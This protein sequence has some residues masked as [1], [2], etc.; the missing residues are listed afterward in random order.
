MPSRLLALAGLE[1]RPISHTERFASIAGSLIATALILT[2][3]QYFLQGQA[4]PLVVASIG[5]SAV[6]LFALPHSPLSQPWPLIGGHVISAFIGV[7]CAKLFPLPLI[8]GPLAVACAIG[9]M[10]YLRCMHPPGGATALAA[11]TGTANIQAL[12]YAFVLTPVA[13]NVVTILVVAICFNW[14]FP[15]RRYPSILAQRKSTESR[16]QAETYDPIAHEDF[17]YA[18]SQIDSFID[19]NEHDLLRIYQL[20]TQRRATGPLAATDIKLGHY[21]SN[22]AYGPEW[23][24]RQIIDQSSSQDPTQDH[25]IYKVV[26][27]AGR[28][29]TAMLSR[30]EFAR[31]AKHDVIRDDENWRRVESDDAG[32]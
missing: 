5:A 27:G 17:V 2:I 31:W 15:W 22:G 9:A 21:Y 3:S 30:A 10:H 8:A 19:V 29:A 26:A 12:G 4:V 1:R 24:V 16:A 20:A 28:R 14:F 6:L 7:T 11:A 18:L 25:V 23:A 32:R 13:L